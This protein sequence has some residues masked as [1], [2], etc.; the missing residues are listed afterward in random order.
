MRILYDSVIDSAVTLTPSSENANYP[1]ENI[2]DGRLS[3][4]FRTT[5]DTSEN[6][7][8]DAGAGNTIMAS[9]Q[10]GIMISNSNNNWVYSNRIGTDGTHNWGNTQSGIYILQSKDT[11]IWQNEIA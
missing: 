3:K 7:V 2:Y 8:I 11:Y 10:N 4:Q 5:G 1:V 6:I 9:G